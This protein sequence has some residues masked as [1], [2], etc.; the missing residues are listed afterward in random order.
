MIYR[1]IAH[2]LDVAVATREPNRIGSNDGY[3]IF[4][5]AIDE[6]IEKE[7]FLTTA[8]TVRRLIVRAARLEVIEESPGKR[9]CLFHLGNMAFPLLPNRQMV[10]QNTS[11]VFSI[12]FL[13]GK[14]LA[15]FRQPF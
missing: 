4:A 14:V 8:G 3:L 2:E 7:R 6:L 9:A 15:G 12:I 13:S 10:C 1:L 11:D 5:I